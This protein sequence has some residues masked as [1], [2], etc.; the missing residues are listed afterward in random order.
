MAA[1]GWRMGLEWLLGDEEWSGNGCMEMGPG[2]PIAWGRPRA[3]GM[4][5]DRKAQA[6]TGAEKTRTGHTPMTTMM[7]VIGAM[8]VDGRK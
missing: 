2:W 4:T 8:Q 7:L 3:Q 1:Q 5:L 6:A